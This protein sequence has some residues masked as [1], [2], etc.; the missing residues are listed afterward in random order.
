MSEHVGPPLQLPVAMLNVPPLLAQSIALTQS[1]RWPLITV[2]VI[3]NEHAR[4]QKANGPAIGDPRQVLGS[5]LITQFNAAAVS[6]L[7]SCN[8]WSPSTFTHNASSAE[9]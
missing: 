5:P 8:T 7:A 9:C 4:L 2:D 1:M 6:W 3:P